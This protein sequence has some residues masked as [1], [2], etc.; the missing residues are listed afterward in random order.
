MWNDLMEYVHGTTTPNAWRVTDVIGVTSKLGIAI[1]LFT[2]LWGLLGVWIRSDQL[3]PWATAAIGAIV[4]LGNGGIMIWN[5]VEEARRS[6]RRQG[7]DVHGAAAPDRG[8][9]PRQCAGH[10]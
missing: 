2:G 10:R 6:R 8:D 5:K 7:R 1:G 3:I 4:V 9:W